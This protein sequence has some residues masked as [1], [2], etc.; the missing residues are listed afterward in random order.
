MKERLSQEKAKLPYNPG[1]RSLNNPDIFEINSYA[2]HGVKDE[3]KVLD[4]LEAGEL[5]S[6]KRI[7]AHKD[8][9]KGRIQECA[10]IE[11]VLRYFEGVP[12]D[13][14][15]D[16]VE[17]AEQREDYI[18]ES[19]SEEAIGFIDNK[20]DIYDVEIID[21]EL[22]NKGIYGPLRDFCVSVSLGMSTHV[23][24]RLMRD[25][26]AFEMTL[27]IEA[28]I[29]PGSEANVPGKIPLDYADSILYNEGLNKDVLAFVE[30]H[31]EVQ[32]HGIDVKPAEDHNF[33]QLL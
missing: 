9:E 23:S 7:S 10:F 22:Q 28:I 25:G 3:D 5:R 12:D 29:N 26:A 15:V 4:I 21:S 16:L 14:N 24:N 8:Q 18:R 30:S 6:P 11:D 32:K 27:P 19:G 1:T 20:L 31:E 13:K 17:F 33:H 2:Y